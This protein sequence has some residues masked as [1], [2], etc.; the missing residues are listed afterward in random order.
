M[1]TEAVQE[2]LPA[3][4]HKHLAAW[5]KVQTKRY[6]KKLKDCQREF[7]EETV[8][9]L[10]VEIRRLLSSVE[11]LG[12]FVPERHLKKGRRLLKNDLNDLD[13]L[14]DLQVKR[15]AVAPWKRR[16]T[17]ARQFLD[18]LVQRE[19]GCLR[20]TEKQVQ[21]IKPA[22]VGRLVERYRDEV[23][24][25][26]KQRFETADFA[27][28]LRAVDRAFAEV[29]RLKQRVDPADTT[30]IHRTRIAFKKFR[31]MV[32]MLA[33]LLPG[34]TEDRLEAM[35]DHQTTMGDIQDAE[36]LLKGFDDFLREGRLT[37]RAGG[38][39]RAELE[40]RRQ[41]AIHRYLR[42]ADQLHEFWP[43]SEPA[44]TQPGESP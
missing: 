44:A 43:L 18:H 3:R 14:R 13:E 24:E 25:R 15:L 11:L 19:A 27:A 30:T 22:S 5:L 12:V 32:E 35:H 38:A 17:G 23:R 20:R 21:R 33:S 42:Q 26:R 28:L 36:V 4:L 7:S 6:R 31:Y 16:F 1:K 34:V 37:P 8:H 40:R 10:R 41:T 39:F 9:D 29:V 2:R